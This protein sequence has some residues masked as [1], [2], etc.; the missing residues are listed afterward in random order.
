M[1]AESRHVKSGLPGCQA[2]VGLQW[3]AVSQADWH[4]LITACDRSSLEQTWAYGAAV[5]ATRGARVRRGVIR[6][7]DEPVAIVQVFE[8]AWRLP[9]L[10]AQLLRGPLLLPTC[11]P[12]KDLP[13]VVTSVEACYRWRDRRILFWT[14]ELPNDPGN[15]H[16]LGDYGLR[17]MTTGYSTV[18]IDLSQSADELRRQLHGKWR[19]MLAAAERGPLRCDVNQG[20]RYL[21]WLTKNYDAYRQAKGFVGPNAALAEAI[22]E[23]SLQKEDVLLLTALHGKDPQAAILV[24]RHGQCATYFLSYT[25][26]EGRRQRAH[27]LLLWRALLVLQELGV[28]W[29]D[30]GGVNPAAPGVARFKLGM[31][32]RLETLSGTYL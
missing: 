15:E 10:W 21:H 28:H 16:I 7:G 8:K 18:W 13:G 27:N 2:P 25:S 23:N 5:A 1:L 4:D 3:D 12:G 29:F 24:M 22:V 31:G 26:P 9:L 14:P 6:R 32:G 19:N 20:G 17:R 11:D 30:L